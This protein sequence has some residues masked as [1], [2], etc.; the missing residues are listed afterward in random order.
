[1]STLD[2]QSLTYYQQFLS[3][4]EALNIPTLGAHP[5]VFLCA[6][7]FF[8][9]PSL[10]HFFIFYH[11]LY[12][13]LCVHLCFSLSLSLLWFGVSD[14]LKVFLSLSLPLFY[15]FIILDFLVGFHFLSLAS[16]S[17]QLPQS[18]KPSRPCSRQPPITGLQELRGGGCREKGAWKS[19]GVVATAWEGRGRKEQRDAT[20]RRRPQLSCR[21]QT[22]DPSFCW[23]SGYLGPSPVLPKLWFLI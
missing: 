13:F 7:L 1:M 10:L 18:H 22:P 17:P 3:P 15:S 2:V 19:W 23:E 8:F 5:N 9:I 12:D 16:L 6:L 20:P 21:E 11:H 14:I 4:W